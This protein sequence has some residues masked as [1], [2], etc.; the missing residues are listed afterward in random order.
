MKPDATCMSNCDAQRPW[1][2][3]GVIGVRDDEE[4]KREKVT[5]RE[6]GRN[7]LQSLFGQR[8][9]VDRMK[10]DAICMSNCD[11][12]RPWIASGVIVVRDDEGI[13]PACAGGTDQRKREKDVCKYQ[14]G[15]TFFTSG[16]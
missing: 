9:R 5:T 1:I 15:S 6:K 3:S 16:A 2:A 13:G 12:Q 7:L 10:A 4:G 11:A 14:L 8:G